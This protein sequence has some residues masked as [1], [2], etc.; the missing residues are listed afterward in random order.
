MYSFMQE[1]FNV[2]VHQ[3]GANFRFFVHIIVNCQISVMEWNH[4]E[5]L[6]EKT[7]ST[8]MEKMCLSAAVIIWSVPLYQTHCV[9]LS[10]VSLSVLLLPYQ[11][12]CFSFM[13]LAAGKDAIRDLKMNKSYW[14][15]QLTW[16]LLS[17]VE[18]EPRNLSENAE[19]GRSRKKRGCFEIPDR[20]EKPCTVCFILPLL[21]TLFSLLNYNHMRLYSGAKTLQT[22]PEMK[23]FIL[24]S[25]KSELPKAEPEDN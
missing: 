25:N 3:Y 18:G 13:H 16:Y 17:S 24:N 9:F 7:Q 6:K 23:L 1:R 20:H 2:V 11:P 21:L 4:K 15:K 5:T 12:F 10:S 14:W 22:F 8:S 19:A